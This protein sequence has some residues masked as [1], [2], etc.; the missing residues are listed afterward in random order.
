[1]K[2]FKEETMNKLKLI[3]ILALGTAI[4]FITACPQ[5]KSGNDGMAM[6]AAAL[7][8][9]SSA[10]TPVK[11]DMTV[12]SW[13]LLNTAISTAGAP[14]CSSCHGGGG[15]GKNK[16]LVW[17]QAGAVTYLGG[18]CPTNSTS[19]LMIKELSPGGIMYAQAASSSK[20]RNAIAGWI[21]NGCKP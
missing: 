18:A 11:P 4:A 6:A 8:A 2:G 17:S 7:A 15:A 14:A 13:A 16:I 19:N 1:M 21:A 20:S 9:T 5:S 10:A 3:T 12:T